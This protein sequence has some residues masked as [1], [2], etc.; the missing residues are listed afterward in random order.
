MKNKILQ[1]V[2]QSELNQNSQCKAL[3]KYKITAKILIQLNKKNPMMT[4]LKKICKKR[5]YSRS[6]SLINNK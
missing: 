5:S 1:L 6:F 4:K 2:L 3:N